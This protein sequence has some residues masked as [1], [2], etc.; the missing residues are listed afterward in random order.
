MNADLVLCGSPATPRSQDDPE[1]GL[2]RKVSPEGA[3][4]VPIQAGVARARR[5]AFYD[6]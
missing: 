4:V 2:D 3:V 1:D 5:C 6:V